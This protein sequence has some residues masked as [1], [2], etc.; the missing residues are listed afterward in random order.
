MGC[1]VH[2]LV[3]LRG[4]IGRSS[5]L[6]DFE[7]NMCFGGKCLGTIVNFRFLATLSVGFIFPGGKMLL[8]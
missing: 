3:P 6:G 2:D 5:S 7:M 4:A 1:C 8:E